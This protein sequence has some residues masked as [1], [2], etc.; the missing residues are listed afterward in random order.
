M[1]GNE[2]VSGKVVVPALSAASSV[3]CLR[4]LGQHDIQT[5][6]ISDRATAP[7]MQ[8]KYCTE[9]AIVPDP[10]V[11]L[12]AYEDALLSL[13]ERADVETIVPL[14]EA[15]VYVL[16][17]NKQSLADH[18]G[19]PWPSLDTLR[20]A[21]DRVEL[22][23]AA[24]AA[25][26]GT[27]K[28][29]TLDEW[30]DWDREVVIKPRYT[31]HGAEYLDGVATSHTHQNSTKYVARDEEPDRDEL[32]REMDHVP[33]VQEYVPDS[34]EYGF[35]AL[36]DHGDAVATFQHRQRR[37]YKYC[38]GPSAYRESVDIPELDAAGRRLLD[39]LDW[40][41]LAM[42]E[43]L[44]DSETGEFE[45]MEVNPRFWTSLP[46]TVQ[47]GVDLP[48][49]Y[50]LQAAGEPITVEPDYEVGVAGHLL[51]GE[52]LHLH[53]I[54]FDDYPLVERP[55]FARSLAEIGASIVKQP[56]FDYLDTNDLG[57]FVQDVRNVAAEVR[58]DA[59][60]GDPRKTRPAAR[61]V[62]TATSQ[63]KADGGSTDDS[64]SL[65]RKLLP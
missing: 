11:D 36:Y 63:V 17:R 58:S 50:C 30:D 31:V 26:V 37:G 10:T 41:G 54:L 16:A 23:D 29:T 5:I 28:T 65:L 59:A 42:V 48:Y 62:S 60:L 34:D 64:K 45:L 38:G 46:F 43:F 32:V 20:M 53:S 44:R 33:M 1:G 14:R 27:P 7:G 61:E 8:S 21:Q 19:T 22:F 9:T 18:V 2:P 40:H 15:D 24:A 57:P 12:Q 39:E 4:S 56:R 51:R 49:Y 13:A 35:F 25:D 3:A 52:M 47:A 55:S 6:A